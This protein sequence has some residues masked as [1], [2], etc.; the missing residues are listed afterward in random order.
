M[1]IE[2]KSFLTLP[3]NIAS[4]G[5]NTVI[6]VLNGAGFKIWKMWLV[7]NGAVTI[8]YQDGSSTSLSGPVALV[9]GGS[10]SFTYDGTAHFTTSIGNAFVINLSGSVQVSGTVYYTRG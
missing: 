10:Q 4:S 6:P 1:P 2:S 9:S 3:I 8:T 7:A 5:N